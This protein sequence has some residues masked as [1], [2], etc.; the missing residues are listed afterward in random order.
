M[1]IK[2]KKRFIVTRKKKKSRKMQ[3]KRAE[4]FTSLLNTFKSSSDRNI[5]IVRI[6][7][8]CKKLKIL[9]QKIKNKKEKIAE[10]FSSSLNIFKSSSDRKI[11]IV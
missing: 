2:G 9:L 6:E 8:N 3:E 1:E 11:E 5:E 10:H 4:H 7:I